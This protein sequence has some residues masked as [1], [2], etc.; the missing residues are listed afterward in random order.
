[1][2]LDDCTILK[3]TYEVLYNRLIYTNLER[4]LKVTKDVDI[5]L[6]KK[7]VLNY[8]YEYCIILKSIHVI[9]YISFSPV[10]RLFAEI[11]INIIQ[12]KLMSFNRYKYTVHILNRYFNY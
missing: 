4:V 7:K 6:N 1:M 10:V 3:I 11:Y 12:Y 5:P 9:F 2:N 8:H